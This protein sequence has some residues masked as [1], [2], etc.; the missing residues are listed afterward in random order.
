MTDAC[1]ASLGGWYIGMVL[2]SNA[3]CQANPTPGYQI[4]NVYDSK[5]TR[6][7][8]LYYYDVVWVCFGV[9]LR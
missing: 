8:V 9:E 4:P 2:L 6:S 7:R 1:R 5:L 3:V